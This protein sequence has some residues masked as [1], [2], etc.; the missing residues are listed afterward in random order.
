MRLASDASEKPSQRSHH[1]A[2]VEED[3]A[4]AQAEVE[5][6]QGRD[7][8]LRRRSTGCWG[9][10]GVDVRQ[11]ET[12]PDRVRV[13]DRLEQRGDHT[14]PACVLG[15]G[16]GNDFGRALCRKHG[17]INSVS[18]PAF[19]FHLHL[20]NSLASTPPLNRLQFSVQDWESTHACNSTTTHIST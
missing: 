16:E 9:K 3:E 15:A 17:E 20:P 5:L 1:F 6:L 13:S 4:V 19:V 10:D 8:W 2:A 14:E 18:P 11:Q 12:S 7:L